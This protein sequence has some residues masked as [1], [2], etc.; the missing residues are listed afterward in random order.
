MTSEGSRKSSP[1][2]EAAVGPASVIAPLPLHPVPPHLM[3]Q[4]G[5]GQKQCQRPG[6]PRPAICHRSRPPSAMALATMGTGH[7]TIPTSPNIAQTVPRA[8]RGGACGP[9]THQTA[10][11]FARDGLR[12]RSRLRCSWQARP[13]VAETGGPCPPRAAP[14]AARAS[15]SYLV[16]AGGTLPRPRS[17]TPGRPR[18]IALDAPRTATRNPRP[19]I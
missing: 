6:L 16:I 17:R 4:N 19:R 15:R 14:A 9:L 18:F 8:F 7:G 11:T 13:Q 5:R 10:Q 3:R 1:P 12:P 2:S